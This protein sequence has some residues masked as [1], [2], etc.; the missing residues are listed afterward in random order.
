MAS[1]QKRSMAFGA[2]PAAVPEVFPAGN[3]LFLD[4]EE[5]KVVRGVLMKSLTNE[6][7]WGA[8]VKDL[9]SVLA[10]F[11]PKPC[12]LKTLG[13][14][15]N[16]SD[17]LVAA[18][19]WFLIFGV[20]L[21]DEQ[22]TKVAQWGAGGLAGYFVFPRF[23]HRVAFGLLMSKIKQ[24][25]IDMIDIVKAHGLE[26]KFEMLNGSLGQYKRASALELCDEFMYAVNFA[27]VGGSQHGTWAVLRFMQ[28]LAVDVPTAD[29]VW[30]KGDMVAMFKANPDA[31]IKEAVRLDAPVT[32][33]CCVF[34]EDATIPFDVSCCSGTQEHRV[35]ANQ[36]RQYVLSIANRDPA[37][38]DNPNHFN[39]ARPNINNMLGWNGAISNPTCYP[40]FC[41]GHWMSVALM[42][43]I[44]CLLDEVKDTS[45]A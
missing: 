36:L 39:P 4:G 24:L 33:A 32:S 27:G 26:S 13:A 5:H 34:K 38:F 31:F 6:E 21:T 8:R 25:R 7:N 42:K 3:L 43:S 9:P 20:K 44:V 23:I 17:K 40:R 18:G 2:V 14:D 35:H 28:R 22:V 29:I 1:D 15:K 10:P 19:V 41:P 12:N 30:P 45:P 16:I 37:E 11:L